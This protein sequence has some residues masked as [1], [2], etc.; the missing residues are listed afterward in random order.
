MW[1]DKINQ[2]PGLFLLLAFA[3][4]LVLAWLLFSDR[5]GSETAAPHDHSAEAGTLWTCSMHPQ[6]RQPE[7]GL[8]PLCGMEL[9]PMRED[10]EGAA[11]PTQVRLSPSAA[12]LAGVQ[13][14][15]LGSSAPP[16]EAGGALRLSGQ[17]RIDES[18]LYSQ[19]AHVPGRIESLQVNTTG[20][21]VRKGQVLASVYSPEILTAQQELIQATKLGSAYEGLLEA[22]REKLRR[23]RISEAQIRRIEQEGRTFDRIQIVADVSGI[24]TER[25]VALGDYVMPGQ[26]LYQ[27]ADLSRLWVELEAYENQL[28]AIREGDLLQI[29]VP[30]QGKSY[31]AKVTFI[32]PLV[33]A[34]RRTTRIRAELPN[35]TGELRPQMLVQA[36]LQSG[37]SPSA[38]ASVLL[39]PRSAVLWTGTRSV[40]YVKA[41]KTEGPVYEMREVS[42]TPSAGGYLVQEGLQAGE[43]VVVNGAFLVDA[44]AQLN[45]KTSMMNRSQAAAATPAAAAPAADTPE[46]EATPALRQHLQ[47]MLTVYLRLKNDLVEARPAAAKKEAASLLTTLDQVP[48]TGMSAPA[49]AYLQKQLQGL[50]PLLQA[51]AAGK[52]LDQMREQF[53]G[54]SN[55]MIALTKA[56]DANE[57]P[58]YLQFC[59]MANNDQGAYWLSAEK[60][61]RNP[62]Y[63]SMMLSCGEVTEEL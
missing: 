21:S 18:R 31:Q 47:N 33:N 38:Q 12:A 17:L 6:I 55:N 30:Q 58:L 32:D 63:G 39:V 28:S 51:I 29:D 15:I 54:V 9:I 43:E 23:Y 4:G 34:E 11:S 46:L 45:N 37:R 41:P 26:T 49:H 36:S 10:A 5:P 57:K 62:Y 59:P 50:Q 8:C 19:A 14:L 61:I 53:I 27:I 7:P 25:N 44:T 24:V 48:H 40:V 2:R 1:K 60:E 22:A 56:F 42:L 16:S 52:E 35:P 13:T 3:A 20:E